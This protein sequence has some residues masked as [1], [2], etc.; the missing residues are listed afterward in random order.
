MLRHTRTAAKRRKRRANKTKLRRKFSANSGQ[1]HF[2]G[3]NASNDNFKKIK[4]LFALCLHFVLPPNNLLTLC[5][6]L[7][8]FAD[9]TQNTKIKPKRKE[10]NKIKQIAKITKKTL[11]TN[12][13]RKIQANLRNQ[14]KTRK[15]QLFRQIQ[16]H[17]FFPTRKFDFS[18]L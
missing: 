18:Y 8:H 17:T 7:K 3:N 6:S 5:P 16:N 1:K 14:Q 12:K 4:K 10:I 9:P 15:N 2:F 11:E 13:N